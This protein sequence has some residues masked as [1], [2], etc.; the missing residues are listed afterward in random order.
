MSLLLELPLLLLTVLCAYLESFVKLFIPLK[1]KSVSGEIVLITGAGQGMGRLTAFEFAKRGSVLV[2]WDINK[3]AVEETAKL[4]KQLGAAA[5]AF[6]VDCSKREEIYQAA[7]KVK[8]NIGD[9]TILINNAGVIFCA[10]LLTLQDSQIQ[11]IFEV[12]TLA[13]FWTT[14]AFLPA[15]MRSNH[16]HVVTVASSA[17]HIGVRFMVDYCSTKHAAVGFH[18]ALTDE[19]ASMGKDGIKTSCLCPGFVDTGFVKNPSTRLM[20][21]LKPEKVVSKLIDGILTN[22]KMIF[23]PSTLQFALLLQILLP[24]RALRAL[25]KMIDIK[26]DAAVGCYDKVK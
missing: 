12:N 5:H 6:V 4:C 13:H 17:G 23:V 14:R 20:P 19:L 8:E 2:L 25:N 10:D 1:R 24:E 9:V 26:F 16:G 22:K 7:D 3:Q 18:R 11:K 21:N 15:M